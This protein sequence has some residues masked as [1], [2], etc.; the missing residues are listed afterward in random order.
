ME[1]ATSVTEN[2]YQVQGAYLMTAH[3]FQDLSPAKE[4]II[5]LVIWAP[6][7]GALKRAFA[8][9]VD[10][11]DDAVGEP[12]QE[13]LLAPGATTWRSILDIAKAQGIRLLESASYR[14]MT[15]GAFVHRQ[16]ESRNYRV[17]FRSRH[18]NPGESPYAIAIGA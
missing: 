9:D 11:D 12:P 1:E 8:F 17:Y 6:S 7:I 14:I 15:D 10:N 13:L 3:H 5:T 4:P 18:D 2:I 16:L